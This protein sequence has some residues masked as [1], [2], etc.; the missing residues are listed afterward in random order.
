[1]TMTNAIVAELDD[2]AAQV[3]AFVA[4]AQ[5]HDRPGQVVILRIVRGA[6]HSSWSHED[7]SDSMAEQ[8]AFLVR[9]LDA[10]FEW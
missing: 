4:E 7:E 5:H 3:Y 2:L 10:D 9:N 1:M 6:G 8:F